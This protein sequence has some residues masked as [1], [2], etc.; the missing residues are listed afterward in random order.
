[1][2]VTIPISR[3]TLL[4]LLLLGALAPTAA[5]AQAQDRADQWAPVR[6]VIR[7]AM[8]ERKVP[9]V[10]IAVSRNGT[11][12]WEEG[13]GLADVERRVPAT[14]GTPY[15]LASISKPITAT[16]LMRLVEEGRIDLDRPI[17]EYLAG[18][19]LTGLAGATSDATVR[20]VLSHTAGLPLHYEFF[21]A[22]DP[23]PR[24]PTD[25]GIAR[26]GVLVNPPGS[27]YEYSNLGYGILERAIERVTGRDYA[28]VVEE[29]VFEPLGMENSEANE[30]TDMA[31]A[32][33]RYDA[34][35]RRIVAYD[36]DHR[37]G[38]AVFSSVRDLIRFGNFHIG[39]APRGT[40]SILSDATRALMQ[41][42]HT[43]DSVPAG[44][45]LG[46]QVTPDAHGYRRISHS[47]GM[48]GV[49]TIL[50]TYP[51][52][53]LVVAVVTNKSDP[54]AFRAAL[55]AAAVALPRFAEGYRREQAEQAAREKV[56]GEP[57]RFA[58][59]AELLGRWEGTVRTYEGTVPLALEFQPDGDVHVKLGEQLESL[60]N[61]TSY[62]NGQL[63]G[64]FAATVPTP[65]TSRRAHQVL[66]NVR[67]RNGVLA[68]QASAITLDAPV[69]FALSSY[70]ELRRAP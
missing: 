9:S 18:V 33:V 13:F 36:F 32:A 8:E 34:E 56:L 57:A 59:P 1:M 45:G 61:F 55:E 4:P 16:A 65:E 31:G 66:L 38:S 67:L 29:M 46:W 58:P 44:Y 70:V 47:G 62:R 30:G 23:Y 68:G 41:R 2:P 49:S 42:A 40:P 21:Y 3:A 10:A 15:S 43:P 11:I 63:T 35:G 6:A 19:K 50:H 27:A 25:E 51:E 28:D 54:V 37:G 20:R 53:G 22:G 7:E 52:A 12:V 60:L 5:P 69:Y 14:P 26:Y 48:P 39:R 64:R 24:R 17:E